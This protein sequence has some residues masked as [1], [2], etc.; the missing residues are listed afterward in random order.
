MNGHHRRE[1]KGKKVVG[2]ER[3]E[4]GREEGRTAYVRASVRLNL[5]FASCGNHHPVGLLGIK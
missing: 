3:E 2:E 4:E 5:S 1:R